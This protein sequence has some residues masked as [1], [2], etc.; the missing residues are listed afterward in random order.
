[1]TNQKEN[2]NLKYY[3]QNWNISIKKKNKASNLFYF[4][5]KLLN[6]NIKNT[7]ALYTQNEKFKKIKVVFFNIKN[8][9]YIKN[10]LFKIIKDKCKKLNQI[11]LN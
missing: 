1:M 11:F 4:V 2:R 3:F 7:Y 5:F 9:F 6:R 8:K 10:F